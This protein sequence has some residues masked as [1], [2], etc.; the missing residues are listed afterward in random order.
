M[1]GYLALAGI[2][3][4]FLT[5]VVGLI[6]SLRNSRK[7][8]SV[9]VLVNSNLTAVMDKLGIETAHSATM[10]GRLKDAG[11]PV[12]TREKTLQPPDPPAGR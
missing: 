4:T 5:A 6:A 9:H 1:T 2:I 7:I 11:L 3:L 10:A 12:P 8:E